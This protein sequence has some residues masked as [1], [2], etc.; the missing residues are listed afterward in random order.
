MRRSSFT[1]HAK[2]RIAERTSISPRDIQLILNWDLYV[3]IGKERKSV[4]HEL[5][6]SSRD[7]DWFVAVYDERTRETITVVPY[8]WHRWVIS[9]DAL[10]KA[11]ELA[12]AGPARFA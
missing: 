3:P 2:I 8:Y 11:R 4:V 6:Y 10:N 12:L 9:S 5:F 7:D 1:K